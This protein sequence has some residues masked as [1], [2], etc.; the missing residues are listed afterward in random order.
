[1]N[2]SREELAA[3]ADGELDPA[4]AAEVAAAV[5]GDPEL[6]RQVEEHR[7]LRR[8]LSSHYDPVASKAVPDRLAAL[9]QADR[10]IDL[11]EARAKRAARRIPRWGWMVGPALAASLALLLLIPRAPTGDS[12]YADRQ[13]ASALDARLSSDP[14]KAGEP[15]VLLSFSR[16]SGELCRVWVAGQGSGIACKDEKGWRIERAGPGIGAG[17]AEYRQAGN[18]LE[19]LMAAAQNMAGES[20]L[21]P[22]QEAEARSRGW[23]R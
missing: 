18:P 5:A 17:Q 9:L 11:G 15:R 6:A 4:R 2:L 12:G 22:A 8:L 3:Y 14:V 23:R 20:A 21:D 19:D 13:V 1:M 16:D 7:A 10:V